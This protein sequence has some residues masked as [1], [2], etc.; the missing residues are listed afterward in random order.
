MYSTEKMQAYCWRNLRHLG[1][2][3][4]RSRKRLFGKK[5]LPINDNTS[6][7]G[8]AVVF[9]NHVFLGLSEKWDP[10]AKDG[11]DCKYQIVFK[12]TLNQEDG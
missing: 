1:N 9:I 6:N 8:E 11:T 3:K 7:R 4:K 12:G 10:D 2:L 5:T